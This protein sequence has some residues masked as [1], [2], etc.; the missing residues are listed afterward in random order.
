MDQ[1]CEICGQHLS[2]C[3]RDHHGI[4]ACI[5]CGA[6]YRI[7]HYD[8]DHKRID[9]GP[10]LLFL[11]KWLPLVRQYWTEEHRNVAPGAYM[12]G[13][14]GY[15]VDGAKHLSD[16]MDAHCGEDG[17]P[18]LDQGAEKTTEEAAIDGCETQ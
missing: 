6:P 9:K 16:W 11:P 7:Y 12:L 1:D 13:M 2:M 18:A 14:S 10:E 8:A 3:W 17:P 4:A 15:E 5:T